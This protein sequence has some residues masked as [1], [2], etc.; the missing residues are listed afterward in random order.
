MR[1]PVVEDA[2]LAVGAANHD[3]RLAADLH[4]GVVTGLLQLRFVAAVHPGLFPDV[5]HLAIEDGLVGIDGSVDAI[6]F[7]ESFE[8][9]HAVPLGR[10]SSFSE[11]RIYARPCGLSMPA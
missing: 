2:D 4:R 8:R 5:G 1:A 11:P 6:G 7:D 9:Q 3:H 10:Y